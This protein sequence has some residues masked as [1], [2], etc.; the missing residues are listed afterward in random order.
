MNA[1]PEGCNGR[2]TRANRGISRRA[3]IFSAR[4]A[5]PNHRERSAAH[6]DDD[7]LVRWSLR[8]RCGR[9]GY[10]VVE[11]GTDAAALE[12]ATSAIDLV[13]LEAAAR[14]ATQGELS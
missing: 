1:A 13:L 9:D 5:Q 8:E 6:V 10:T 7:E 14:D 4:Q 2:P 3:A 11:A 12:Q